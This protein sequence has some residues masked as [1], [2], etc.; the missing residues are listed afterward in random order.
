MDI[1]GKMI[2]GHHRKS[3]LGSPLMIASRIQ[4]VLRLAYPHICWENNCLY[5]VKISR[6]DLGHGGERFGE[7]RKMRNGAKMGVKD[8]AF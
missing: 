8:D 3:V 6:G 4:Q 1:L 7:C 5:F 2:I